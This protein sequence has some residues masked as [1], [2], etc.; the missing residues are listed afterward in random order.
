MHNRA[1]ITPY[2]T[3]PSHLLSQDA[4]K[5]WERM[6]E[7]L[8][9]VQRITP[10]TKRWFTD[11]LAKDDDL[12]SYLTSPTYYSFTGRKG[13]WTY[14]HG[15]THIPFCWHPNVQGQILVF[16]PRGDA[17]PEALKNLLEKI[18]EPPV[19]IN[20]V[21]IKSESA[22]S[23]P[24]TH[25]AIDGNREI[26]FVPIIERVLDWKYP[27]RVL[28]TEKTAH[29]TNPAFKRIRNRIRKAEGYNIQTEPLTNTNR[30]DVERFIRHYA[31]GHS[32]HKD[33][34]KEF[35]HLYSTMLDELKTTNSRMTGAAFRI[36]GQIVAF[37]L[38]DV[39]NTQN[40]TA[41]RH[42]NLC[43]NSYVGLSDY[44]MKATAHTLY[45]QGI[46]RLNIGGSETASLDDYK[47]KFLPAIS[48]NLCSVQ[49]VIDDA[50]FLYPQKRPARTHELYKAAV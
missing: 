46:H 10:S 44:V 49:A 42:A 21:R 14:T 24:A 4:I 35:V 43:D 11:V 32:T 12:D 25:T 39:S 30:R 27:V 36:D 22:L 28:S 37:T 34:A 45:A 15:N 2:G 38:W 16:P 8:D 13:L 5:T 20:L 23:Q 26:N 7:C 40:P 17:A 29:M 19:G 31:A 6:V 9:G 41:N 18:P 50:P 33:Q 48:I 47:N 1:N 3:R